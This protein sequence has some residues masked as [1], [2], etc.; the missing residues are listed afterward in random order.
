MVESSSAMPFAR[1]FH[2]DESFGAANSTPYSLLALAQSSGMTVT[3]GYA[4]FDVTGLAPGGSTTVEV[5]LPAGDMPNVVLNYGPTST[6][7]TPRWY[8]FIFD[9]TTGAQFA[10]NVITLHYVDG[11]R[12]D[13][14][15]NAN[16]LITG[17]PW[18]AGFSYPNDLDGVLDADED[19]APNGGDANGDSVPDR[20]QSNVA[21]LPD[22]NSNYVTLQST[23]PMQTL[24][25]VTALDGSTLRII[26]GLRVPN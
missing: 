8:E 9:G 19:G 1:L 7:P 11:L 4:G 15:L 13:A 12:G 21:S 5:T 23:M 16:G 14:D 3:R 10:G 20:M 2:A 22:I 24:H 17:S 18:G 26:P 25:Y 6:D